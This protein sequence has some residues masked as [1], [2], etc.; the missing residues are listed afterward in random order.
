MAGKSIAQQQRERLEKGAKLA[1][2]GSANSTR[3]NVWEVENGGGHVYTVRVNE[4]DRPT[5]CNCKDFEQ[6]GDVVGMCKHQRAVFITA[7]AHQRI[8]AAEG[9]ASR[10]INEAEGDVSAFKALLAEYVQ[11]P[12]VTRER[13]YL[14]AMAEVLPRVHG[15]LVLDSALQGGVLPLLDLKQITDLGGAP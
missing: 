4:N 10:R 2:L 5:H 13:L 14:E 8:S 9:Y 12:E 1:A 11:A 15:M 3:R 7:K 6:R